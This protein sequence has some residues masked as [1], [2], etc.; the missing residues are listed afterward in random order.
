MRNEAF[1]IGIET[2]IKAQRNLLFD[3]LRRSNSEELI[4]IQQ[5]T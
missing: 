1:L 2:G 4:E 3:P 5:L